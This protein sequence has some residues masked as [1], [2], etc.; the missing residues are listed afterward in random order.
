L[1]TGL[2]QERYFVVKGILV[3]TVKTVFILGAGASKPYGLPIGSELY[4]DLITKFGSN[5][6]LRRDLLNL[7]PLSEKHIENFVKNLKYSGLTSVDAFLERREEFTDI[8]KACIAFELL[9]RENLEIMW[10]SNRNWMKYLYQRMVTPTLEEFSQNE[11]GFIMYNYDRTLE[12]FLH[13]SLINTYDKDEASCAAILNGLPIIHLHGRLG[14]LPWQGRKMSVPFPLGASMN[15]LVIEECQKEIRIVHEDIADRDIEFKNA[16]E[17]LR[18]GIRI[19]FMGFGY[20]SQNVER[21]KY[22][23]VAAPREAQGTAQGLTQKEEGE[24]RALF[25]GK[26][27]TLQR[28][29]DCYDFLR[30][31]VN[32][33]P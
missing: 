4:Q 31:S 12:K 9:S 33:A 30:E 6:T 24:A 25:M 18:N 11:V 22:A 29:H 26:P 5:T 10:S 20:A 13:T 32:F 16:R 8:G 19:Y 3:I 21:L 2:R 7:I 17:L 28:G 14:Y 15:P 1:N 23:E 27:I